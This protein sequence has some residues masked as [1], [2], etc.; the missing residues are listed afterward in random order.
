MTEFQDTKLHFNANKREQFLLLSGF[1]KTKIHDFLYT[2]IIYCIS[3]I[4]YLKYFFTNFKTA[5]YCVWY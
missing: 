1:A 2:A 3:T 5:I 4:F